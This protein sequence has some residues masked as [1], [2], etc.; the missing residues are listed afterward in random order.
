MAQDAK[1]KR[2]D[3]LE[4]EVA[5]LREQVNWFKK[6]FFGPKKERTPAPSQEG[7]I[8]LFDDETLSS[9]TEAE[10]T[11]EETVTVVAAHTRKRK[12][13]GH[14]AELLKD[15]PIEK[16]HHTLTGESGRCDWCAHDLKEIGQSAIRKELVF[17]PATMK[18]VHHI[19]HAYECPN[20]KADGEDAIYKAPMPQL[21]LRNSLG[22]ASVISEVIQQKFMYH[23]PFYRQESIWKAIGL[24][25]SRRTLANWVT[26]I[27]HRY[28]EPIYRQYHAHLLQQSVLHADETPVKCLQSN[29]A[30]NYFWQVRTS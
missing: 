10:T 22:S 8:S 19:Q 24:K 11:E 7:V 13:H 28:F 15:L 3:Q 21:P 1:D 16:V 25:V 20:C 14:K 17:V 30:T 9:F 12:K 23:L 5:F 29:K 18:V 4:K 26:T 27:A 6:Q 2:I